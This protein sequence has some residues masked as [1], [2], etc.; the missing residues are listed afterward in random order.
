MGTTRFQYFVLA[1]TNTMASLRTLLVCS[2]LVVVCT[3]VAAAEILCFQCEESVTTKDSS[4]G[5]K[6]T[7]E[8]RTEKSGKGACYYGLKITQ[9]KD[10]KEVKKFVRGAQESIAITAGEKLDVTFC[11]KDKCNGNE[12]PNGAFLNKPFALAT[13]SSLLVSLLFWKSF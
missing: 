8:T 6:F 11:D 5:A 1:Q 7:N 4:C 10:K 12:I 9:D 13:I 3:Y 2:V